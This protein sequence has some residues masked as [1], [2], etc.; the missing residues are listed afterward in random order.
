MLIIKTVIYLG[1]LAAAGGVDPEPPAG[2]A[3]TTWRAT[4][5]LTLIVA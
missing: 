1:V 5:C 2:I 4:V 3:G